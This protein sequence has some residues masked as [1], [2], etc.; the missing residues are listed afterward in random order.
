MQDYS[1]IAIALKNIVGKNNVLEQ[2][3]DLALYA[4]DGEALDKA[5]PDLVVLPANTAE[6]QAVVK[7][8]H[9]HKIPFT[10]RGA[11]TGL[12][13]GATT[14]Y[15]G[16]SLVLSRMVKI[17]NI[18]SENE[19]ALVESGVTNSAV[20]QA[21][22]K[23]NLCFAPDPSSQTAS[24]IGGNIAENAG[25]P[26]TLKYGTTTDHVLSMKVVL[27]DGTLT[28]YG[29]NSICH[30][31]LDWLTL[32]TGSEGTL[33]V[34]TEANLRLLPLPETVET[35]LVYFSTLESGAEAVSRIVAAGIV[36]C[37]MEMI[38]QLTINAVEDAFNL[39]LNRFAEAL[40]IIEIDGSKL[41]VEREKIN[42][43]SMLEACDTLSYTWAK[44]AYER[45]QMWKARKA[46][47]AAYGRL[48]PHGYVLDGVV[49]RNK[50]A[51]ALHTIKDIAEKYE[52]V[53]A[54]VVHA[55]DGNLHPCLLYNGADEAVVARVLKASYAILKMCVDL[56]GTLSGEHGIGI[57][58]AEAMPFLFSANDLSVMEWVKRAFDPELYCNPGKILPHP[59][60][61]GESGMR[62]LARHKLSLTC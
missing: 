48:A 50:L 8:A 51:L 52:V 53:I 54:N 39:G 1:S 23:F 7:A 59:A 20:S 25:G 2:R 29:S 58:K 35:A 43:G 28:T 62:P 60:L 34:V 44:S 37:A 9:Q 57:E 16:I 5:M 4:Y 61:C 42:I 55:G 11:G 22:A 33:G 45:A 38:D 31:G 30:L 24:T 15:G 56:G 10:A 19:T 6:V 27:P 14:I 36:P 41:R 12:S 40:L 17:I 32:L 49:P 18:D 3:V 46:A 26:H 47:V 13:G 21:A